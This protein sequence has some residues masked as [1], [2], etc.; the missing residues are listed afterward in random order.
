MPRVLSTVTVGPGPSGVVK[1]T[2]NPDS[3]RSRTYWDC[4]FVNSS[5]T[6]IKPS[7]F[8]GPTGTKLMLG[9]G[10]G[11]KLGF[12]GLLPVT[13]NPQPNKRLHPCSFAAALI[14]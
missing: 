8:Q 3:S 11:Q 14:P 12:C 13:L 9:P 2:G 5:G 10:T 1:M 7:V 6:M 4:S